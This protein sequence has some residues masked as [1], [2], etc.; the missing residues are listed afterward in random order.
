MTKSKISILVLSLSPNCNEFYMAKV[1]KKL[2][3]LDPPTEEESFYISTQLKDDY[4][5]DGGPGEVRLLCTFYHEPLCT[6]IE[7]KANVFAIANH[8]ALKLDVHV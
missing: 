1:T 6:L 2:I 4:T 3:V 8:T 5:K 7:T